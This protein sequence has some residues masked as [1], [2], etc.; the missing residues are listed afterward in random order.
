MS[1]LFNTLSGFVIAFLPRSKHLNFVAAITIRSDFGAQENSLSWFPLFPHLF[2]VKW[3]DWM[4]WSL[5]FE[6]LW[7]K[8]Q[9]T[10]GDGFSSS[11]VWMWELDYKESWALENWCFWTAVLEKTL[12]SPLDCKEIKPVHPK[13]NQSWIFIGRTDA[14]A[15]APMLGPLNVK[16]WLIWRN[17]AAGKDWR[18]EGKATT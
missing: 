9:F 1:L 16:N 13:G 3:W 5:L 6:C 14:K 7:C 12:E 4:P 11:H 10:Q 8:S 15:E 18:Q 2:A 17:P